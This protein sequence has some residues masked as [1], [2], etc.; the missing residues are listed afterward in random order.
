M[1][2]DYLPQPPPDDKHMDS[3]WG[4]QVS[5]SARRGRVSVGKG[6]TIRKGINGI[7]ISAK[8]SPFIPRPATAASTPPHPFKVIAANLPASHPD[9]PFGCVRVVFGTVNSVVPTI[10]DY[11]TL[12]DVALDG[13]TDTP[14]RSP[15]LGCSE[16]GGVWLKTNWVG[17]D[18]FKYLDTVEVVFFASASPPEDDE[19]TSYSLLANV[20]VVG[21]AVTE[22]F[23]STTSSR[24]VTRFKCGTAPAMY[25]WEGQTAML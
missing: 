4:R 14:P 6:L 13:T 22:V 15:I 1:A 9:G 5:A 8:A 10:E 25:F 21:N 11:V 19:E 2:S 3:V 16:S 20:V 12:D 24:D 23:Q 18:P 17:D 7:V